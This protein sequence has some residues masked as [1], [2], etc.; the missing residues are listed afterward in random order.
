MKTS[1]D[2]VK[3]NQL[4]SDYE[5][6]LLQNISQFKGQWIAVLNRNIVARNKSLKHVIKTVD[7]LHLNTIPLYLKVPEGTVTM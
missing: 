4:N 6:L 3:Q 5:W 2:N 7:T 1:K